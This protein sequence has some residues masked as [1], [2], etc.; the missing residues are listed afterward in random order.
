MTIGKPHYVEG[1]VADFE[2]NRWNLS[3]N[4][5]VG[6]IN[7][8]RWW[9]DLVYKNLGAKTGDEDIG[10]SETW[11][12]S[13]SA[14]DEIIKIDEDSYGFEDMIWEANLK[15]NPDIKIHRRQNNTANYIYNIH[16]RNISTGGWLEERQEA[17][18]EDAPK[19]QEAI[20]INEKP[21]NGITSLRF[22]F[23]FLKKAIPLLPRAIARDIRRRLN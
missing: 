4:H 19:Q 20:D 5:C 12:F 11:A 21:M 6:V 15:N 8:A 1:V 10:M 22:A 9:S 14:I 23:H 13:R 7:G 2:K 16:G 17:C 3:G 18:Q